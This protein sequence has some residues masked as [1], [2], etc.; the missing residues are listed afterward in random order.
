[1]PR[2]KIASAKSWKVKSRSYHSTGGYKG[3]GIDS[4]GDYPFDITMD[5]YHE[6]SEC[7]YYEY[8]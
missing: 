8:V 1:M 6:L 3:E 5:I 4:Y 7:R 2:K